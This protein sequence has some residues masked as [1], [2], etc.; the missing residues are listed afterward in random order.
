[1][2]EY[3]YPL[4][5][6]GSEKLKRKI[7]EAPFVPIGALGTVVFLGAGLRAFQR[8]QSGKSQLMMRGRILAQVKIV[9]MSWCS[10]CR[11]GCCALLLV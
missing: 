7:R 2:S 8:G 6:T 1:M 11:V 9:S 4:P 3:D 10:G 5:E